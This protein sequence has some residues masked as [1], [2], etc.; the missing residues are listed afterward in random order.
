[1][2][3][4]QNASSESVHCCNTTANARATANG[5]TRSAAGSASVNGSV[6][7]QNQDQVAAPATTNPSPG[8]GKMTTTRATTT[9]RDM[10]SCWA[11]IFGVPESPSR[12]SELGNT[13]HPWSAVEPLRGSGGCASTLLPAASACP[14]GTPLP[15]LQSPPVRWRLHRQSGGPSRQDWAGGGDRWEANLIRP[16]AH[17]R[18]FRPFVRPSTHSATS[19]SNDFTNHTGGRAGS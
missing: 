6:N 16:G 10:A 2:T 8:R 7:A 9:T 18:R 19:G 5:S 11:P 12:G 4:R 15:Q 14:P 17:A 1:M 3:T 13:N